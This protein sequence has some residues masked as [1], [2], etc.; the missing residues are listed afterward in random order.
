MTA[1][2]NKTRRRKG[3]GAL[4][5]VRRSLWNEHSGQFEEVKLFQVAEDIKD[6]RNNFIRK[7]VTGTG[8]TPQQAKVRLERSK[9]RFYMKIGMLHAVPANLRGL[10]SSPQLSDYFAEWYENLNPEKVSSSKRL[11]YKGIFHNHVLPALGKKHLA[12]LRFDD[13]EKFIHTTLPA[14]RKTVKGEITDERLL[15]SNSILNIYWAL[16]NCLTTAMHQGHLHRNPLKLV[17]PPRFQAPRENIPHYMHVTVGMFRAMKE[18]NDPDYDRFFLSLLGLRRG[19]RLGLAWKNIILTGSNPRMTISQTLTREPGLG[20]T[21]KPSTKN[22]K[23]RTVP[24]AGPFLE[25]L[26]KLKKDRDAQKKDPNFQPSALFEDLVFLTPTGRPID[27]NTDNDRW[28]ACQKRY[29]APASIRAHA[30]RHV[31]A[32]YLADLNVGIE[33]AQEI[34]GHQSESLAY[35]YA[36]QTGKR[37]RKDMETYGRRLAEDMAKPRRNAPQKPQDSS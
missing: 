32:T 1:S 37:S 25:L 36:R 15:S 6:P 23:D 20:L 21:I 29:K 22:G 12:E 30:M 31:A 14:K 9:A 27:L 28:R 4:Y 8:Q 2:A 33:V 7:R 24:L 19:E 18:N 11:K 13:L 34:L 35:Y 26:Q 3:Q 10:R 17:S 16:N 5:K